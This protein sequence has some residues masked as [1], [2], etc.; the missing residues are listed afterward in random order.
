ME[1]MLAEIID[2]LRHMERTGQSPPMNTH[3]A[4]DWT[5]NETSSFSKS[6][7][8]TTATNIPGARIHTAY[9]PVD[10]PEELSKSAV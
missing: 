1:D 3:F 2:I 4:P 8:I 10:S 6:S 5:S 7:P 9:G